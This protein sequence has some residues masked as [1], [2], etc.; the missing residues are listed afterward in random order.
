MTTTEF[1]K[2]LQLHGFEF[3]V[4]SLVLSDLG[5]NFVAGADVV[6]NF[7]DDSDVRNHFE[8]NNMRFLSF[9]NYFKGKHELGSLV[10]ICV[11]MVKKLI[12]SSIGSNVLSQQDFEFMVAECKHL[13]N[14]RPVAFKESLRDPE[15]IIPMPITPEMM[16]YGREL[17]SVNMVPFIQPIDLADPIFEGDP[18]VILK[19]NHAKLRKVRQNL[20]KVYNE[21][22]IFKLE[23]TQN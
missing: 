13:V 20:I 5:S 22:F 17:L 11:K 6:G 3:G 14:R 15:L 9:E 12:S 19:D 8:E 23:F 21:E 7:F 10:E 18:K 4:P 16:L 2:C 1:L